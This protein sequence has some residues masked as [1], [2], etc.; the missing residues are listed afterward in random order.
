MTVEIPKLKPC[1]F[2]GEPAV[3][4]QDGE[5]GKLVGCDNSNCNPFPM[6]GGDTLAEAAEAWND[7]API[8]EVGN[9]DG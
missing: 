7:R 5:K 1:P 3:V 2:C 4:I 6:A 8:T 9:A